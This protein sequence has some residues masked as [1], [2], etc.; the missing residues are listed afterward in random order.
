MNKTAHVTS[1][2]ALSPDAAGGSRGRVGK[3]GV[4]LRQQG[5]PAPGRIDSARLAP[6]VRPCLYRVA[7]RDPASLR[8]ISASYWACT[9]VAI[10]REEHEMRPW[11]DPR[12]PALAEVVTCALLATSLLG[13]ISSVR[14]RQLGSGGAPVEWLQRRKARCSEGGATDLR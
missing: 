10:D 1:P 11:Q 14:S 9:L 5:R 8:A 4:L 2:L 3:R 12:L 13:W 6:N 7:N